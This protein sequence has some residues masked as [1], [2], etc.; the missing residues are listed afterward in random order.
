MIVTAIMK[1]LCF[2]SCLLIFSTF[3]QPLERQLYERYFKALYSYEPAIV[4][5]NNISEL[6]VW[7]T[8]KWENSSSKKKK[9]VVQFRKDGRPVKA[10]SREPFGGDTLVAT[11]A[12]DSL[13][14]LIEFKEWSPVRVS[15]A[16]D[17]IRRHYFFRY[18]GRRLQQ[19]FSYRM[20]G[21]YSHEA[22]LF[23]D[24]LVYSADGKTA[25]I[26]HGSANGFKP[27]FGQFPPLVYPSNSKVTTLQ[28]GGENSFGRLLDKESDWRQP[29]NYLNEQLKIIQQYFA[30]SCLNPT[31]VSAT[32]GSRVSHYFREVNTVAPL[33]LVFSRETFDQLTNA[34]YLDTLNQLLTIKTEQSSVEPTSMEDR[35]HHSITI[36]H[37]NKALQLLFSEGIAESSRGINEYSRDSIQTFYTYTD[38]GWQQ[39]RLEY[40]YNS[41]VFRAQEIA[42]NPETNQPVKEKLPTWVVEERMEIIVRQ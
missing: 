1:I 20:T 17:D 40:H 25:S 8:E 38:F 21:T 23:C 7:R 14:N 19:V 13:G 32:N 18:N 12:Y 6:I 26:F 37:Y 24:S 27:P 29:C 33:V 5:E 11:Y 16:A 15:Y 31:I 4:R 39:N 28:E 10:S 34:F 3:A 36:F 2:F 30:V 22:V 41:S 42:A 35:F 9:I